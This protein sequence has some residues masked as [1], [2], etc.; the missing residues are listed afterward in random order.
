MT[1]LVAHSISFSGCFCQVMLF[2]IADLGIFFMAEDLTQTMLCVYVL[3][4]S[5]P[6]TLHAQLLVGNHTAELF[7]LAEEQRYAHEYGDSGVCKT[8]VKESVASSNLQEL[9]DWKLSQE[10][11]GQERTPNPAEHKNAPQAPHLP[12]F[13]HHFQPTYDDHNA[14]C[15]D[16]CISPT[17][18]FRE[19]QASEER[20]NK[21]GVQ[22]SRM[23]LKTYE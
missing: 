21:H 2:F 19:T 15:A 13:T 14:G 6:S 3:Y 5:A 11:S 12:N 23:D 1:H 7:Q 10:K 16:I 9:S 20:Y 17:Q 4:S 22:T 18:K 8:A